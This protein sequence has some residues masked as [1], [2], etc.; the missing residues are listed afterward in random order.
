MV[1]SAPR[2]NSAICGGSGIITG[3][4][5]TQQ[6]N[7]LSLLLRAGALPATLDVVEERSVGPSLGADSIRAGITAGGGVGD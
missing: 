1:I 7:E 5:T 3:Q 6:T 4:F 2:I